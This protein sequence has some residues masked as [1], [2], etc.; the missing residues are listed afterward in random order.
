MI[1]SRFKTQSDD[2]RPMNWPIKHPYWCT[3]SG[4]GFGDDEDDPEYSIIVAY[5]DNEEEILSNW[6]EAY[7]IDSEEAEEY[8]FTS[9][10]AK[11]DWFKEAV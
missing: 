1:R 10:F 6:P 4:G 3:G 8:T 2:Y 7:D 11:P 5:A 9:R